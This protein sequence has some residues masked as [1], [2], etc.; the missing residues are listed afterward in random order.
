MY[1]QDGSIKA[2]IDVVKAT[3]EFN[4]TNP[5]W[6][7][8]LGDLYDMGSAADDAVAAGDTKAYSMRPELRHA[9][10]LAAA[11]LKTK[12]KDYSGVVSLIRSK[13]EF[14]EDPLLA[15][16]WRSRWKGWGCI[17]RRWRSWSGRTGCI[18]RR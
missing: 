4:P 2:A 6:Y 11:M 10:K 18:A 7:V 15:Q 1:L 12:S 8:D 17:T 3:I 5:I 13:P 14:M 16:F 9:R